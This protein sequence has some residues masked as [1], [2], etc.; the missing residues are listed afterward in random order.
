MTG[1]RIRLDEEFMGV[2]LNSS[3]CPG[4]VERF[5]RA[6]SKIIRESVGQSSWLRWTI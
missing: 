6:R 3:A 1:T 4:P 2:S 5:Q